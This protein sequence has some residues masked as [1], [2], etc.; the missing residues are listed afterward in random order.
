MA[1][2]TTADEFFTADGFNGIMGLGYPG[3]VEDYTGAEAEPLLTQLVDAAARSPRGRSRLGLRGRPTMA[4]GGVDESAL[5]S[6]V[7]YVSTQKFSYDEMGYDIDEYM[8]YLVK[9]SSLTVAGRSTCRRPTSRAATAARPST[10]A[11]RC[12]TCRR[13]RSTRSRPRSTRSSPRR[14][15]GRWRTRRCSSRW[16][17]TSPTNRTSPTSRRSCSTWA[18]TMR[19]LEPEHYVFKYDDIY[20]WGVGESTFPIVGDVALNELAVVFDQ[21]NNKVGFAARRAAS[22]DAATTLPS[23]S[24]STRTGLQEQAPL[25]ERR[26]RRQPRRRRRARALGPRRRACPAL[27]AAGA[28]G[29]PRRGRG[30]HPPPRAAAA[31]A[32]RPSERGHA[33][34]GR[35]T[36]ASRR[37][38]PRGRAARARAWRLGVGRRALP[39]APRSTDDPGR[40]GPARRHRARPPRTRDAG[41][42]RALAAEVGAAAARGGCSATGSLLGRARAAARPAP[43]P[44]PPG[45]PSAGRN[46]SA[47]PSMQKRAPF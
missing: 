11:R 17:R 36:G 23:W 18:A 32:S 1:A 39:L 8:Y 2:I 27:L 41:A 30:R 34:A 38:S 21:A 40:P 22:D 35:R 6:N 19:V 12:S 31:V 13:P 44:R 24:T 47:P 4:L 16:S 3:L 15:A 9:L 25:Q 14:T 45:A 42:P 33:S 29:G 26:G 7:S 28:R 10:A 46:T 20:I 43:R 37:P 5:A